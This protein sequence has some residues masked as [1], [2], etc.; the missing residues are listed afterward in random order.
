MRRFPI[1]AIAC[2][3]L[4]L[5]ACGGTTTKQASIR[6]ATAEQLAGES[7]AL[8]AALRRG[9]SCAAA[10]TAKTLRTQVTRAIASGAIPRSLAAPA[11]NASSRLA[12]RTVCIRPPAPPPTPPAAP[13]C[14]QIDARRK[15]L[16]QQKHSLDKHKKD[17]AEAAPKHEIDQEEH[18][19]DEQRKSCK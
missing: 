18:A 9:D 19:L 3:C 7:D 5:A 17:R 1:G 2:A 15:A 6:R 16:E 10:G 12:G 8:A 4:L 14:A 11:R 13:M